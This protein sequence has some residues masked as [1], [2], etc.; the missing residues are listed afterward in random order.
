MG[1]GN[2]DGDWLAGSTPPSSLAEKFYTSQFTYRS[3]LS[4]TCYTPPAHQRG[5]GRIA[6]PVASAKEAPMAR[7]LTHQYRDA[8][9]LP[10]FNRHRLMHAVDLVRQSCTT[11]GCGDRGA[12]RGR[13][14]REQRQA[15]ILPL[16][17]KNTTRTLRLALLRPVRGTHL[18]ER[19]FIVCQHLMRV[20]RCFFSRGLLRGTPPQGGRVDDIRDHRIARRDARH[21]PPC[22]GARPLGWSSSDRSPQA[23]KP[24]GTDAHKH[25]D[26]SDGDVSLQNF[27][28]SASVRGAHNEWAT[29]RRAAHPHRL[30]P[31]G[32]YFEEV[33]N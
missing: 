21:R 20:T 12:G 32:L 33:P 4:T 6:H 24:T 19:T 9:P 13:E 17:P 8:K 16:A 26:A 31:R 18:A 27:S 11:M 25:C 7:P 28:I 2:C 5:T 22:P 3:H 30:R 1:K 23:L 10:P 29:L 14:G 15:E